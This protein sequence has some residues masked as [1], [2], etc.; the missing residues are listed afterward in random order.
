MTDSNFSQKDNPD[1]TRS[2]NRL[3]A[4]NCKQDQRGRITASTVLFLNSTLYMTGTAGNT[5]ELF[6]GYFN[7]LGGLIVCKLF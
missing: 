3:D 4:D 1:Q 5:E 7:T 6:F 2:M